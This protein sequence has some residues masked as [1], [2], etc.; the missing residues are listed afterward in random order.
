[1]V[2]RRW[3]YINRYDDVPLYAATANIQSTTGKGLAARK[4]EV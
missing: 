4:R 2:H 1:M 3:G